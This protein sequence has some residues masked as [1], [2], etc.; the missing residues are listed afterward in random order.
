MKINCPKCDAEIEIDSEQLPD[1]ACDDA[2]CT[3]PECDYDFKY[4]W[5]ATL[6]VR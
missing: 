2:D 5:Y 4:G 6:E 3:C 1:C